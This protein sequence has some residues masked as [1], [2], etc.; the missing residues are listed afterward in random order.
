MA[1][2]GRA[3]PVRHA[4]RSPIRPGRV[5]PSLADDTEA[6]GRGTVGVRSVLAAID[7]AWELP[8]DSEAFAVTPVAAI[9][10]RDMARD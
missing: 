8:G 5:T 2:E 4:Y 9:R 1:A 7:H 3:R 10:V 6:L